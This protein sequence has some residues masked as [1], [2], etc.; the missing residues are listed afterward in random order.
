MTDV[1]EAPS[2]HREG[3]DHIYAAL[4]PEGFAQLKDVVEASGSE[5]GKVQRALVLAKLG[6][7]AD[8]QNGK[9][10]RGNLGRTAFRDAVV[11]GYLREKKQAP[12]S[13]IVAEFEG[14]ASSP[15]V[16]NSLA[17]LRKAGAVDVGRDGSRSPVYQL[18]G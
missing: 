7:A 4:P 17:R 11:L 10:T 2:Q 3:L 13:A 16:Y 5:R 18:L 1:K 6:E 15:Q 8:G 9:W 12:M 14:L